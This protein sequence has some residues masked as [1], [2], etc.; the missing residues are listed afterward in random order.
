VEGFPQLCGGIS[1]VVW[2]DFRS[3]VEGFPQ[4]CGHLTA[5]PYIWYDGKK[6]VAMMAKL[7]KNYLVE[8]RNVLNE[9]RANNMSLQELRF[10]AI[11]LSKINPRDI[12][13]RIVRF[14]M[15]DFKAIMELAAVKPNYLQR[16]TDSLL[17]KVVN[18]PTE[19]GGYES[20]QLFKRCRVD[21]DENSQ[22]YVEIDAH[23]DALPLMFDFKRDY[24]SYPLFN[25]LRLRS[26]NQIRMYELL[27]QYRKPGVRIYSLAELKKDL[28]LNANE[29][30][31]Y[32]NFRRDVL[33]V[34][35]KALL[36]H[37]DIKFIYEPHG[38]KGPGGKILQLKF[39][40]EENKNYIDQLTL[41]MFIDERK[42]AEN[43]VVDLDAINSDEAD[44]L[45]ELGRITRKEDK[46]VFLREAVNNEFSIKQ[47]TILYDIVIQD[48]PLLVHGDDWIKCYHHFMAKYNYMKEK[49][50]RGEL[51]YPFGYL[52]SI[53]GKL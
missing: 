30:P 53:I 29:Y 18:V 48:M 38:K 7:K 10:F 12:N 23:D 33:D 20:F 32:A 6:A 49:E 8:K 41:D 9:I 39:I 24:F 17:C 21:K 50:S 28:W 36:E 11:Y 42:A 46:L 47:I 5:S 2:R 3:C 37:T 15:D 35:Q 43:D 1:A 16:V 4:L 26:P 45:L 51:K 27:R 19:R 44:E 25:A 31:L 40:I 22:W 34:C 14:P 52:K 13:T